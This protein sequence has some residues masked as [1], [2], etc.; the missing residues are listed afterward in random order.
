MRRGRHQHPW[1]RRSTRLD[2]KDSTG[3]LLTFT[4]Q[5]WTHLIAAAR[6]G[7]AS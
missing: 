3:P 4:A 2:S 1:R 5:A 6:R 7:R